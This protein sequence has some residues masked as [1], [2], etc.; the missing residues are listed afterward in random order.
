MSKYRNGNIIFPSTYTIEKTAPIDDRMVVES[1][2]DLTNGSIEYP[3]VGMTVNIA[4]KEDLY[5]L[6]QLPVN[7]LD[8]W[9]RIKGADEVELNVSD[10][11]DELKQI[12]AD[13]KQLVENTKNE[14]LGGDEIA[15]AY[16][17]VKEIA[18][19]IGQHNIDY[20][21]LKQAAK[22]NL[23]EAV[24]D[25]KEIISQLDD[26]LTNSDNKFDAKINELDTRLT[27]ELNS[28][29]SSL[30]DLIENMKNKEELDRHEILEFI[31]IERITRANADD[32]LQVNI[33]NE[34]NIREY[35]DNQ[36]KSDLAN[37]AKTR[38]D[39]DIQLQKNIDEEADTRYKED[40]KLTNDLAIERDARTAEDNRLNTNLGIETDNR[41]NADLELDNK[42]RQETNT[43]ENQQNTLNLA[44]FYEERERI[45]EDNK[46]HERIEDTKDLLV[47]KINDLSDVV[48]KNLLDLRNEDL[49]HRTDLE[50]L[51]SDT[52]NE[53]N[54]T[55]K[56][57]KMKH[58]SD[59][60]EL[61]DTINSKE[62]N[63]K[64]ELNT[65][66]SDRKVAE[67]AIQD[68]LIVESEARA[69]QD[70]LILD[71]LE[72]ER[73]GRKVAI[74]TL[75]NSLESE[76][77]TRADNDDQL[78]DEITT[79]IVNRRIGDD[80]IKELIK[81]EEQD[82]TDAD[83]LLQNKINEAKDEFEIKL[84]NVK[85]ELLGG[86][87]LDKTLDSIKDISLWIN[88]HKD[89]FE[90][91][92][93]FANQLKIEEANARI[94]GDAK[95]QANIDKEAQTREEK[96]AEITTALT[97]EIND[98]DAAITTIRG[99]LTTEK[100]N[101]ETAITTLRGELQTEANT[102][103]T[104]DKALDSAIKLEASERESADKTLQINIDKVESDRI[105]VDNQIISDLQAE[106]N[107][108]IAKD[109][110]IVSDLTFE[111]NTRETNDI[112]LK[113]NIDKVKLDLEER[114][115]KLMIDLLGG[116]EIGDTEKGTILN[117]ISEI[118]NWISTH[119][120]EYATLKKFVEDFK[121]AE[122]EIRK[123]T[124]D[125]LQTNIDNEAK[126]REQ[127][128]NQIKSDIDNEAKT[129][130]D[131]DDLL[132]TDLNTEIQARKDGDTT[133]QTNIDNE[134][135]ARTDGDKQT[136]IR[137]DN[138]DA[139]FDA[140]VEESKY[141]RPAVPDHW[142]TEK[143]G[144]IEGGLHRRSNEITNKTFSQMFDIMLY[145]TL[146]PEIVEPSI[147]LIYNGDDT[148]GAISSML[149]GD[150]LPVASDFK[151]TYDRGSVNYTN[152]NGDKFYAGVPTTNTLSMT[153]D[154]FGKNAAEKTYIVTYKVV[155]G[156]G[157]NL[158]DNKTDPATT[159]KYAGGTFTL[160]K[161]I[162]A[163]NPIYANTNLINSV[164][165]Q[166][167]NDY[168]KDDITLILSIPNET[169]TNKF[170]LH[171]PSGLTLKSVNQSVMTNGAFEGIINMVANGTVQHNGVTYNKY[172]RTKTNTSIQGAS[173]YKVVIAKKS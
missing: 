121:K 151:N 110:Q 80:N 101:R 145:P 112:K 125:Q 23:D 6:T 3:Y 158:K 166:G 16:D 136:N 133:L 50:N 11:R 38:E 62:A 147:S 86:E 94:D 116:T 42:I 52:K 29:V 27:S 163:V 12:E 84:G 107:A 58:D 106:E 144:G 43:R 154:A 100:N 149:V 67:K 46:I 146:Q 168:I 130:K 39:V 37:E 41:I 104:A 170:E 78:K 131:T 165:S 40:V 65:E 142:L 137:I 51:V 28:N 140:A 127:V 148:D 89:Q 83:I 53:I 113:N 103:N 59:K 47:N 108:R 124:D 167:I 75:I 132:R 143:V 164:N 91:L 150:K 111:S 134:A 71:T 5:V 105:N 99:E 63:L 119:S 98:R 1:I 72:I 155:F 93:N 17:T 82:R 159:P 79:E 14:L 138:I 77:K 152:A 20:E 70:K 88:E 162:N 123:V 139:K 122:E 10:L 8:N 97:K 161:Q 87:D 9:K 73:N 120:Q 117:S 36:I 69:E 76:S 68:N 26:R 15:E 13:L 25:I 109:E 171:V 2:Q 24:N 57:L 126:T 85:K 30:L 160:T 90:T 19:W 153:D 55:I 115:N 66:I 156:A 22:D 48:N 173:V 60:S 129:R 44:I 34:A 61:I 135:T 31:R 32:Q 56:S 4:G 45:E 114:L 118:P 7:V 96:D 81:H 128:D 157:A 49:T 33:D 92:E 102:R 64:S 54:D 74:N 21:G 169:E 95:L 172:V 35:T 18:D 141:Y